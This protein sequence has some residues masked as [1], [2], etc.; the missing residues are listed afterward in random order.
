MHQLRT[1]NMETQ[2]EWHEAFRDH[3]ANMYRTS[4][5]DM[6]RGNEVHVRADFPSG[7]G[8]HD[9]PYRHDILFRNTGF[10]RV[11]SAL[12]S[13]P[14]RDT[15]PSFEEQ[16]SGLPSVTKFP[17]G[18]RRPP[19]AAGGKKIGHVT[20][21]WGTT[22][23]VSGALTF[24]ARPPTTPRTSQSLTPRS[25]RPATSSLPSSSL[26]PDMTRNPFRSTTGTLATPAAMPPPLSARESRLEAPDAASKASTLTEATARRSI[27]FSD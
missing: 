4:Y 12:R 26:Q 23:P 18:A 27:R 15:L 3:A 24:R 10:D 2:M 1:G 16:K 20:P 8:G 11:Y 13:H 17:R 22:M 7:Y 6:V 9:P 14:M 25:A 5:S 19:S 21:P